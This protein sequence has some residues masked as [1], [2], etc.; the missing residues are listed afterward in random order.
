MGLLS[1][2]GAIVA[3]LSLGASAFP[4]TALQAEEWTPSYH[5]DSRQTLKYQIFPHTPAAFASMDPVATAWTYLR[6]EAASFGLTPDLYGLRLQKQQESLIGWHLRFSQLQNDVPIEGA[7]IIIS[8][9]KSDNRIYSVYSTVQPRPMTLTVNSKRLVLDHAYDRAWNFL[10]VQGKLFE[11]PAGKLIYITEGEQLRAAYRVELSTTAPYGA[12]LVYVDAESG[13]VLRYEDQRISHKPW[14]ET[15]RI[16]AKGPV[17]N[18]RQAFAEW[19]NSQEK[20][21]QEAAPTPAMGEA[22]VF[23]PDPRT[24]LMSNTLQDTSSASAFENAYFQR[25][26]KDISFDGTVYKLEGPWVKILDWDPPTAAPSTTTNGQWTATRGNNAFNDAMTYFHIDQSQ[27]YMQSLGFVGARGIQALP[28]EVDSNGVNGDDNSYFQPGTN[29]L[30][31]GHGCVDD[32]EDADVI[33]HEYGHAIH[34]GINSSWSGGDT[35]A[36]GEGFGDYWAASYSLSTPQGAQFFP[37]NIYSWDGHGEGSP[38]WPG[39]ILNATAARFDPSRNYAAH[40]PI[41]GGFQSDEL[42][43]TPLFQSLVALRALGV[44]REEVDTIILQAQF[45]L[46][47]D[48]TMRDMG[49]AILLTAQQLYPNGPHARVFKDNFLRHNIIEEPHAVLNATAT[50]IQDASGD[51]IVNPGEEVDLNITVKNSGTL[52][53]TRV[54]GTISSLDQLATA[55]T[56]SSDYPDLEPGQSSANA[57]ALR[58][59]VNP[60]APCGSLLKL[61]L[62]VQYDD[63]SVSFPVELRLGKAKGVS[64]ASN[65]NIPVPDADPKGAVD[66]IEVS[67]NGTVSDQFK[68]GVKVKHSYRG[69]L[70]I[71]LISP[72]GKTVILHDRT[73]IGADDV[74]GVYPTTLTPKEALSKILGESLSG[75]WQLQVSDLASTDVGTLESWN[76]E[77]ITSYQCQ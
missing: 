41:D 12:W 9:R 20:L 66:A 5:R 31:F 37:H 49:Q 27:R 14:A 57:T 3:W 17:A 77:D 67:A 10:G 58:I 46:G 50:R 8:V 40:M 1:T 52:V 13:K 18:R 56:P 35:G 34:F 33:L 70:R 36:I 43:S 76:I 60:D 11:A 26:L 68:V 71:T 24:S 64:L 4:F 38:C 65:P 28:I 21:R 72:S 42:W 74:I 25:E 16:L 32:N 59:R 62:T 48:V 6:A 54:Q 55:V 39:R 23:D 22:R 75:K 63:Q 7:E 30:S 44:P 2:P 47:S 69:D 19:Q 29:R 51:G 45:G 53:A 73:G 61:Q 15:T